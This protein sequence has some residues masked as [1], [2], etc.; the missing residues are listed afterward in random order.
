MITVTERAAAK[1]DEAMGQQPESV[2]GIRLEAETSG[3]CGPGCG[4]SSVTYQ[5]YPDTSQPEATDTVVDQ[6]QTPLLISE[7]SRPVLEGATI[8]FVE[9]ESAGP[10]FTLLPDST[11]E[12]S[13]GECGCDGDCD[14]DGD[15]GC[16]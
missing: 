6:T 10:S 1:L 16:S 12:A 9:D 4:C 13:S 2:Y 3:G 14:C 8:D 11:A 15:C 7:E 5:M